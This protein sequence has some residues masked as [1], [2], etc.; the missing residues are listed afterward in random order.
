D[1]GR[2]PFTFWANLFLDYSFKISGRYRGSVN[3][4]IDNV[5]NTKTIQSTITSPNLEGIYAS[6]DEILDGTL[7]STYQQMIVDAGD[8][9]TAYGLW[10]TRFGSWSARLGVKFSF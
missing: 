6:N 7:A 1:L 2:L 8:V 10:E 5:T 4:Q 9:N 3:L